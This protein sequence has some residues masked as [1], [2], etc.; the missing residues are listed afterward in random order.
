[1]TDR[2]FAILALDGSGLRAVVTAVILERLEAKLKRYDRDKQIKDYFDLIS[3]NSTGS[4]IA[5]ALAKGIPASKI[6]QLF[7]DRAVKMFPP[8]GLAL[9]NLLRRL[10]PN[11]SEPFYDG[12]G[13]EE[14]LK[15]NSIFGTLDLFGALAKPTLIASYDTY[16]RQTVIFDST[17]PAHSQ[18]K[19][20]E[21]CR[22]AT[23]MPIAFPEYLLTNK[24]FLQQQQQ[25]GNK[26]ITPRDGQQ[27]L[28]FID[29]AIVAD[30]PE[31]NGISKRLKWNDNPPQDAKW[32]I[33]SKVDLTQIIV[34]SFLTGNRV[35]PFSVGW[36]L[37]Q[38]VSPKNHLPLLDLAF[39]RPTE[40]IASQII[41]PANFFCFQ[42]EFNRDFFV[43][44]ANN[45]TLSALEKATEFAITSQRLDLSLDRLV[46]TLVAAK[47]LPNARVAA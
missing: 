1:M 44:T 41:S 10:N 30:R 3:A 31:L 5:C 22:A 13:L 33:T 26:I 42:P 35:K 39:D 8:F 7:L 36:G 27:Y 21:V 6:K 19:T 29:G 15:Q 23:A 46:N 43:F 45:T 14:V 47:N 24:T 12:I 40:N 37:N 28:P 38:W 9:F 4:I 25:Q 2:T 32:G 20:W 34:A 16:N 18:I 11:Y 17:Q